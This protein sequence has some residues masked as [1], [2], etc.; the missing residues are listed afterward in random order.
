M[1]PV[2][3]PDAFGEMERHLRQERVASCPRPAAVNRYSESLGAAWALTGMNI[4][5]AAITLALAVAVTWRAC[6]RAVLRFWR[7][8]R[9]PLSP[10]GWAG[11]LY[12]LLFIGL[13]FWKSWQ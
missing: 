7:W 4:V 8:M 6:G 13:Y 9:Q 2:H 1:L 5:F 12:A 3:V 10:L 11:W